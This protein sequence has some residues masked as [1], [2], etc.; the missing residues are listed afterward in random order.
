MAKGWRNPRK[1][2]YLGSTTFNLF[3]NSC[4]DVIE[5]VP[6]K[7]GAAR[8]SHFEKSISFLIIPVWFQS[9]VGLTQ[10]LSQAAL[11][12]LVK[13][14]TK[15]PFRFN[16][17][18]DRMKFWQVAARPEASHGQKVMADERLN[19]ATYFFSRSGQEWSNAIFGHAD[20]RPDLR[21][22]LAVEVKHSHGLGFILR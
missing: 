19:R 2:L 14:K 7:P 18:L 8:S 11:T 22:R 17:S 1:N 12:R 13:R 20:V 21:I 6:I 5:N 3:Q 16:F 9:I 10:V 4:F 15:M